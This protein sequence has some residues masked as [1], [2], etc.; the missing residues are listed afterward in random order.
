MTKPEP[1]AEACGMVGTSPPGTI[2]GI[3]EVEFVVALTRTTPGAA[4]R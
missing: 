1:S 2:L 4:R 3:A